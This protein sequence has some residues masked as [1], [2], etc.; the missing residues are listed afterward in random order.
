MTPI[1]ARNKM[2]YDVTIKNNNDEINAV[3]EEYK[4]VQENKHV[5]LFSIEL[6]KNKKA[7]RQFKCISAF[8]FNKVYLYISESNHFP[9]LL[10]LIFYFNSFFLSCD[11]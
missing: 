8:L 3:I 5:Y 2:F 10:L 4:D 6:K 7:E 11:F 9:L 1:Q